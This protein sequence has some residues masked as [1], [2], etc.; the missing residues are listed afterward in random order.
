M[1]GGVATFRSADPG[2][3]RR[4]SLRSFQPSW[5]GYIPLMPATKT[6]RAS[7]WIPIYDSDFTEEF[8]R[9]QAAAIVANGGVPSTATVIVERRRIETWGS[10]LAPGHA[11][12]VH[13]A[14][15]DEA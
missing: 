9:R 15:E 4:R 11:W 5:R 7:V 2:P 13:M 1:F 12:I 8:A 14:W 3:Y 10:P 6:Q